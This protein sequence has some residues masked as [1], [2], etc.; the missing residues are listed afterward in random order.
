MPS[1]YQESIP[2]P[3]AQ[4]AAGEAFNPGLTPGVFSLE[5]DKR[6]TDSERS[7]LESIASIHRSL[8][9]VRFYSGCRCHTLP[10]RKKTEER[11]IGAMAEMGWRS[12]GAPRATWPLRIREG[13]PGNPMAPPPSVTTGRATVRSVLLAPSA[14]QGD[15]Q[16]EHRPT[17]HPPN[18]S[19]PPTLGRKDPE[20]PGFK[21]LA[22]AFTIVVEGWLAGGK[23]TYLHEGAGGRTHNGTVDHLPH[24]PTL[25][26]H[27]NRSRLAHR[28]ACISTG[29]LGPMQAGIRIGGEGPEERRPAALMPMAGTIRSATGRPWNVIRTGSGYRGDR[30][31]TA[32]R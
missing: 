22:G 20:T 11:R 28:R 5:S 4:P 9:K 12:G 1:A 32:S 3:P 25:E 13:I 27:V 6:N 23:D 18:G 19:D 10:N 24:R 16:T 7:P 31:I 8:A 15:L 26:N 30:P 21:L 17:V 14:C 29:D 2:A